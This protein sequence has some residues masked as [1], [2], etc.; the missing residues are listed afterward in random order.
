MC[1]G[2]SSGTCVMAE[3][4]HG[5]TGGPPLQDPGTATGSNGQ[6]NDR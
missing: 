6:L 4:G 3:E 5:G 1:G 2:G